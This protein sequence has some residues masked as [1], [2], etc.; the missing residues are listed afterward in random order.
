MSFIIRSVSVILVT[1]IFCIGG[2]K[3]EQHTVAEA[4]HKMA[5]TKKLHGSITE[6]VPG[7]HG[8]TSSVQ[9][10]TITDAAYEISVIDDATVKVN[11]ETFR[12][13]YA[14]ANNAY[15]FTGDKYAFSTL[16]YQYL[17]NVIYI[18]W[19][20]PATNYSGEVWNP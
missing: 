16:R 20:N 14:D 13:D 8:F 4:V 11:D 10:F 12:Y 19:S 6:S 5:G 2:C 15:F 1:L 17:T 18:T 9:T 3:K 7:H